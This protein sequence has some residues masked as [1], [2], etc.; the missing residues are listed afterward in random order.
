MFASWSMARRVAFVASAA[1]AALVLTPAA[2]ALEGI[3]GRHAIFYPSLELIYQHD[4]NYFIEN[5][6]EVSAD[7]FIAHAHFKVEVP[8]ARQHLTLEYHPQLRNV[9]VKDS[10]RSGFDLDDDVQHFWNLDAKLQGSNMF[11]VGIHQNFRI[12]NIELQSLD[13]NQGDLV[14]GFEQFWHHD[15]DVD[16]NW[17]G[18]RQGATLKFGK[19]DSAW[20]DADKAPAWWETNGLNLGIEY[21]YKFTGLTKFLVGLDYTDTTQDYTKELRDASGIQ[22]IDSQRIDFDLGFKGELGRT[23]TGQARIGF[24]SLDFDEVAS[25]FGGLQF[26]G[27]DFDGLTLSADVT[28]SFSRYSKLIFGGDRN[29][30]HS[31]YIVAE[32][33]TVRDNTYYVSNR[34]AFT[35]S[36]Q[37]QGSRIGWTLVGGFQRNAYDTPTLDENGVLQE[38]EDDIVDLRAEVGFH[39]LEHLSFRLNY[40]YEERESNHDED[41]Y[42]DNLVIFQMQFGF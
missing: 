35:F 12:A 17:E 9:D 7:T 25:A 16:F 14:R 10:S 39:P 32:G 30:N 11:W 38:R 22:S 42:T 2:H 6:N 13:P 3:Q 21:A 23:T 29:V 1:A 37:P 19:E 15:L 41:D 26:V 28:K 20:D 24:A 33:N 4:D 40:R 18:S 31:S 34:A 36:N 8:G 27:D 5:G